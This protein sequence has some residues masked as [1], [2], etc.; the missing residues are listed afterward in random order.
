MDSTI[1]VEV[2]CKALPDITMNEVKQLQAV[3]AGEVHASRAGID[4]P[5]DTVTTNALQ[6]DIAM[7]SVDG[8]CVRLP[9]EG[10][11]VKTEKCIK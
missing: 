1:I 5:V 3:V 10:F 8:L 2:M 9:A 6:A 4:L 7:P 11:L